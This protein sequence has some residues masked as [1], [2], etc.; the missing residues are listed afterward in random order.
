[1]ARKG[2][3]Q[4]RTII[5][6]IIVAPFFLNDLA[7][8]FIKDFTEW[9][10]IDYIVVK[11][12]PLIFIAYLLRKG[13]ITY[14]DL[15]LKKIG[16]ARFVFFTVVMTA[17]GVV[18]DQAGFDFLESILPDTRIGRIPIDEGSFL[19]TFDLYFGL[20]YV[21]ILEEVIF[22]GLAFTF[23]RQRLK[24]ILG[25]FIVSSLI[26]GAIHWSLGLAAVVSAGVIG[27]MFMFA[28]WRTGSVLPT[29]AAHFIVNYVSFS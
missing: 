26:F 14:A 22:R 28:M 18:M 20:A 25:V 4:N 15:G 2:P 12:L 19:Y 6:A 24:S 21:A 10:L 7:N 13:Q 8:I 5:F 23:L 16:M 3:L 9:I 29:M 11:A 27:A 1:M 17:L